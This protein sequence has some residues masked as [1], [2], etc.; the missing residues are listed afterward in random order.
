MNLQQRVPL[1]KS[2]LEAYK[3]EL[4]RRYFA[5][6]TVACDPSMYMLTETRTSNL[7]SSSYARPDM[8]SQESVCVTRVYSMSV[9]QLA[10]TAFSMRG[11][12]EGAKARI[13]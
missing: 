8:E 5:C 6:S 2:G 11:S 4:A 12:L 13:T 1:H 9:Y 3:L 7:E 10:T